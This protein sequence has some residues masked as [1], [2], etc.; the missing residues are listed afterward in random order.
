MNIDL[1]AQTDVQAFADDTALSTIS[2]SV[3][4]IQS[5]ANSLLDLI[6]KWGVSVKLNFNLAKCEAVLLTRKTKIKDINLV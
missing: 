5:I 1:S 2:N 4:E 3:D 6:H